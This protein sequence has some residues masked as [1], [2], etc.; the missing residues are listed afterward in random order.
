M[1][2]TPKELE[3]TALAYHEL[4]EPL[5]FAPLAKIVA[6]A[7]ALESRTRVLD[8]GCGTG[9][10]TRELIER[11]SKEIRVSGLDANPGMLA[12]AQRYL[13]AVDFKQGDASALP[14]ADG[15]FDAVVSQFALMLFEDRTQSLREMWRVLS[16]GGTLTVAVFDGLSDN[17]AYAKI[18]DT[19]ERLVGTAIG[20]ALRFPFSMGDV[21]QLTSVFEEAG[22]LSTNIRTVQTDVEFSSAM[23]LTRAD[24]EGWFPFAGLQVT[25]QDQRVI[26]EE[27]AKVFRSPR[28]KDGES[29][30]FTVSAHIVSATKS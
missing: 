2:S 14:Y 4:L 19:Y 29:I 27:L 7:A 26:A 18:A 9:A 11:V 8:V 21:D 13:P 5:L 6:E 15:S 12:V 20:N 23:H 17:D 16:S 25:K 28:E 24:S 22:I 3:Q 1:T 30:A 10:L